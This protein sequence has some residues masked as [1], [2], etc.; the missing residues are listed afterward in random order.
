MDYTD[1]LGFI[2]TDYRYNV[3]LEFW[4]EEDYALYMRDH[5]DRIE[6]EGIRADGYVEATLTA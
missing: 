1:V 5:R 2:V 4:C 6:S 3:T